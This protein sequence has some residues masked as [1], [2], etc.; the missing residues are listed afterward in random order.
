M[1]CKISM[2]KW[3]TLFCVLISNYGI[4]ARLFLEWQV[5]NM[6]KILFYLGSV[7]ETLDTLLELIKII[8]HC[9]YCTDYILN[10]I[11]MNCED[12]EEQEEPTRLLTPINFPI[13]IFIFTYLNATLDMFICFPIWEV[14]SLVYYKQSPQ[15]HIFNNT[16]VVIVQH[17]LHFHFYGLL[18]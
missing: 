13:Y 12:D 8:S 17:L 6:G 18:G 4:N 14:I 7:N 16:R 15:G 10:L 9:L 1:W 3:E 5:Q 2:L 11:D